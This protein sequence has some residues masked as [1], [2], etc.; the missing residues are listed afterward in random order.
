VHTKDTKGNTCEMKLRELTHFLDS[1][2]PLSFQEG[3]DN[4]GLQL[5]LPDK[6]INS[7]LLTVDVTEAVLDEAAYAGCDMIISHHPVI[8]AGLKRL[9]GQSLAERILLKAIRLDIAIYS[10]HTNL[11]VINN[12]VSRKMAEKMDLMNVRVLTHLR[13]RLL[14]LVTF[15]P[16]NHLDKVKEA[17]FDAGAGVTGGYD[18]CGFSSHG[19][20]SFRGSE[21]THPFVGEKG[22]VHFEKETRFET[23]LFSHLKDK[24]IEAL[25]KAHPY[26]E[27]VY[28]IYMLE[29]ENIE[30][31]MGCTGELRK[32]MEEKEFLKLISELFTARGLRYSGITG[33]KIKS[34]ALC[35]G[36]GGFLINDAIAAG[37]DAFV[38][39]EIKYHSY[40]ETGEK[41]LLADIGHYES[42][43]F[44]AEILHD[45]I[46][47]KFP[48]F[49]LRFSEINTNPINYL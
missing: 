30:A 26:E 29:N 48:K 43:K 46:I 13:N 33:K 6:E 8:F 44:S 37:A 17:I 35:G 21:S 14:K 15:V 47:K 25:I 22:K 20:G 7:A 11:D 36:S 39:A 10:S 16:D 32:A 27:P 24:V 9:S 5:G 12:G 38:T 2:V 4:S 34:V 31:G 42:E 41:I 28:D 19:T 40:F 18:N 45:L 49:A 1:A 23:I 3:Y